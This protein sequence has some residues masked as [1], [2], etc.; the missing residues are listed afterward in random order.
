MIWTKAG[1]LGE[2]AKAITC[3]DFYCG[4]LPEA[5]IHHPTPD[6]LF[7]FFASKSELWIQLKAAHK[8]GCFSILLCYNRRRCNFINPSLELQ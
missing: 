6:K 3:N 7:I 4:R 5:P 1:I 2:T 8:L